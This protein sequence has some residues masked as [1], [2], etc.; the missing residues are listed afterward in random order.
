MARRPP[1]AARARE[2]ADPPERRDRPRSGW[3]C[4]G[5]ASRRTTSSTTEAGPR[6]LTE[7]FDGRSQ[8]LVYHFMFGPDWDAGCPSCSFAAD[9]FDRGIVHLAAARRDDGLRLARAGRE[10]GGVQAADGLGLHLGVG[11]RAATSTST[12]ACRSR[13]SSSARRRRVQLP[14]GRAPRD[15]L[16]GLSAFV[17]DGGVVYRTYSAYGR[18][19]DIGRQRLPAARPRVQGPRRDRRRRLGPAARRVPGA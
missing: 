5:S 14:A 4:R 1:R 3:R 15:E 17:L 18:G 13:P 19:L 12:S 9:E 16:P 7:L 8:L 10:A 2:G 6:T 11:V